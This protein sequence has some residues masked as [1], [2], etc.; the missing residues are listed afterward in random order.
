MTAASARSPVGIP[1]C[2]NP[3]SRSLTGWSRVSSKKDFL[4][5]PVQQFEAT[6]VQ[7]V[8]DLLDAY[9]DISFQARNLGTALRVWERAMQDPVRPT[10]ILGV[11]GSLMAGG[12]RKVLR[13]LIRH[14]LVDVVVSVGSQPYQ[15]MYAARGYNFWKASPDVDDLELR[16]HM[17]DRL[18]DTIVDEDK[19]RETDDYL[20]AL[21][22]KLD[23]ARTYTTREIMRFFGDHFKDVQESWVAEAA[24]Q[25]TPVFVPTIHDSS[26]GIGMVQNYTKAKAEGKPYPKLDMIR[27]AYEL[28]QVKYKSEKTCIVYLGGGVPKNYIQQTEVIAEVLGHD[29]GGHQYAIQLTQ[30]MPVW[31]AL[32]GCTFKEAQSWGKIAKDADFVQ[33]HVDITIGLPLLAT[34]LIQKRHLWEGRKR[35]RF[36][37]DGDELR[38]IRQV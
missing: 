19:F 16:E 33:A 32:S 17:L 15:D 1:F 34:A 7:T 11:A 23:P 12:M 20:G 18:Y 27:D 2:A 36:D 28:A 8:A 21:A 3:A 9:G 13:D 30:D 14:K 4:K 37:Y 29:A 31:G 10:V 38:A 24:R 26:I 25:E 22:A 5:T 6:K 35:L